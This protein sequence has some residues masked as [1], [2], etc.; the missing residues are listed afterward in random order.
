MDYICHYQKH[1]RTC[2]RGLHLSAQ[3]QIF[4]VKMDLIPSLSRSKGDCCSL[5]GFQRLSY[6]DCKKAQE[7]EFYCLY[8]YWWWWYCGFFGVFFPVSFFPNWERRHRPV[9]I[10]VL[11][12]K[13]NSISHLMVDGCSRWW[14]NQEERIYHTLWRHKKKKRGERSQ[15][16]AENRLNST[17][18]GPTVT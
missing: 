1:L 12:N 7:W 15:I 18:G 11:W 2:L 4:F 17:E 10:D 16:G 9:T 14:K 13:P 8:F 6:W 3:I 5:L